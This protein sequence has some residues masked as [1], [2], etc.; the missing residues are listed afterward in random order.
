MKERLLFVTK[1]NE[2]YEE[3]FHYVAELSKTL[4]TGIKN[5]MVYYSPIMEMLKDDMAAVVFAEAGEF[6]AAREILHKSGHP[7]KEGKGDSRRC[8]D[9]GKE[10]IAA[11][12]KI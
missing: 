3:G 2:D 12:V 6:E 7:I 10:A 8:E 5:L 1:G 11:P 9:K 4:N